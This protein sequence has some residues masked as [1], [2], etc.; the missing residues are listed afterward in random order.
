[1]PVLDRYQND[2]KLLEFFNL[3]GSEFAE[4]FS[5]TTD[6]FIPLVPDTGITNPLTGLATLPYEGQVL[7]AGPKLNHKISVRPAPSA[8]T[9]YRTA[10]QA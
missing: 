9:P 5:L 2:K 6:D 4:Q 7:D 1:M 3:N 10:G 8:T